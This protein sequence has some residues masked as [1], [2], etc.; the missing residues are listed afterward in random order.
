MKGFFT[1][2]SCLLI[3]LLEVSQMIMNVKKTKQPNKLNTNFETSTDELKFEA[4]RSR[5]CELNNDTIV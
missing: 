3:F 1:D 2:V 5:R 4:F